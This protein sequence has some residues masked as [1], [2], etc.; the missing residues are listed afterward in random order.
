MNRHRFLIGA[1]AIIFM[2]RASYAQDSTWSSKEQ[3]GFIVSLL[4]DGRGDIWA[5]TEDEGVSRFSGGKWTNYKVKDGLG[6]ANA[7]ALTSDRL[8]R[9][10]VGHLN[11]GVSVWNGK[12]WKN[13]GVSEGPLGERVWVM[14]T[15][16][17]DGDVWI[18]HNAGLTRYSLGNDTWTHLN[19]ANGFPTDE[20]SALAFDSL[21]RLYVGTQHEGIYVGSPDDNFA[22]WAAHKGAETMPN[23]PAGEGLPSNR[24]NDLLVTDDNTL[25]A[26]TDTG[27]AQS[28]DF[29]EHWSFVRGRDWKEKVEGQKLKPVVPADSKQELLRE[30]YVTSLVEDDRALLWIGYRRNGYEV[31]R[32]LVDRS[33]FF[34]PADKGGD[35]PYASAMLPLGDGSVL[36]GYYKDGAKISDKVPPFVPTPAEEKWAQQK[37]GWRMPVVA[38]RGIAPFPKAAGAPDAPELERLLELVRNRTRT[39]DGTRVVQLPDDWTT[40]GTWLGR[41][42]RYWASLNAM[43]SPY[44][45]LWGAGKEKIEYAAGIG[46]NAG[47]ND[48]LRYWVHSLYTADPRSLEMPSVYLESRVEK[49]LVKW[50]DNPAKGKYRRQSEWD[51]HGEGYPMTKNGPDVYVTLAVPKGDYVLSLFDRN[52]DGHDGY[53]R[54]RDYLVSV[55]PHPVG[56]DLFDISG[57][58]KAPELATSRWRDFWGSSWKRFAVRG[59]QQLTIKLDRNYSYNTILAGVFLDEINEEPD[60]YFDANTGEGAPDQW[61]AASV[62]PKP[63]DALAE[64]LWDELQKAKADDVLWWSANGRLFYQALLR[65]YQPALMRTA[66]PQTGALWRRI[67]TCNYVLCRYPEWEKAQER[68]GLT[69][70]RTIKLDLRWDKK[71]SYNGRGREAV[72]D[73]KQRATAATAKAVALNSKQGT[74]PLFDA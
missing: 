31:R 69:T 30:D 17:F 3:G 23:V 43:L 70:A 54:A 11:H 20:V 33:S 8:G 22:S 64:A 62:Q 32:P 65:F 67:G 42:G 38:N 37:R 16:P 27:L 2:A 57:F 52:K 4:R 73:H 7:Y 74:S 46:P 39:P 9:V 55:R 41:Y 26:A 48:K 24:I 50:D 19:R 15:S 34:S 49:G 12:S 1:F 47:A 5:G 40:Q 60:P 44:D 72:L 59:P 21:G 51:D 25:Y 71:S 45:Y 53:N 68:R 29:G 13:Y 35:F 36:L 10:W 61:R 66:T 63:E 56:T 58:D 6:D 18:A 14:A 28:S